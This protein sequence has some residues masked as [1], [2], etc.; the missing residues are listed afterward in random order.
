VLAGVH[1][2]SGA[3]HVLLMLVFSWV[4]VLETEA[5]LQ[6]QSE[7]GVVTTKGSALRGSALGEPRALKAG[8]IKD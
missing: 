1:N 3:P 7:V 2:L 5:W 4:L 6:T 8:G